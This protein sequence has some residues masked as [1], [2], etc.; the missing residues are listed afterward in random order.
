MA[1]CDSDRNKDI[2]RNKIECPAML[3]SKD[4]SGSADP[5]VTFQCF[6]V[7]GKQ[8]SFGNRKVA[9][10]R[11]LV[12]GLG[13]GQPA[14]TELQLTWVLHL[15]LEKLENRESLVFDHWVSAILET[16]KYVDSCF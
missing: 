5:V 4:K 15:D 10:V 13:A 2:L 1:S 12:L 9:S 8:G 7:W 14:N 6:W 11:S 16:G 3:G